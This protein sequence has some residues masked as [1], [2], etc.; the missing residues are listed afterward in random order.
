[1]PA[2][3]Y[4]VVIVGHGLAQS[5]AYLTAIANVFAARGWMV[6]AIDA[7]TFG[8]RAP[9]AKFQVDNVTDYQT[10]PGVAYKGPDGI[11][12]EVRGEHNGPLDFFGA[13]K[14][15]GAL[16]DQLR[17]QPFDISQVVKLLRQSPDLSPLDTGSGAP[18]I[19]S[20]K[21][22]YFGDSFGA[23][24]GV[25]AAAIEPGVK[26]WV[27]NVVGGALLLEIAGHGP[28]I[29]ALLAAAG[30][31]NFQFGAE[32]FDESH[33]LNNIAQLITDPGDPI[34][35]AALLVKSPGPLK[36]RKTG[37]RNLLFTEVIY[38][39]L[40]AN[41]GGEALARAA[42]LGLALPN[43]GSNAGIADITNL[44][45]NVGRVPFLDVAPDAKGAIHDTPIPGVTS[46]MVQLSP[47]QHG[48]NAVQNRGLR[49]FAIPYNRPGAQPFKH[50]DE[51]KKLNVR[52]TY[53]ELQALVVRY[54]DDAFRGGVPNVV[55]IP[56][57]LRDVDDDG[58]MDA[59]DADPTNPH[60][61]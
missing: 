49:S 19:D 57:P 59:T 14:N 52:C 46:V 44:E 10:R 15:L 28:A 21:I 8:A 3:G 58:A 27:L 53:R 32:R 39:E 5:R 29:S 50:L 6:A 36:S 20:S 34:D 23:I 11:A 17:Q 41:E 60:V 33:P 7:V 31:F 45:N 48:Y 2:S 56:R 30:T 42:G 43:V 18:K 37:P 22:A 16:R 25:T 24:T 40:V 26:A 38:D 55:G 51:D 9:E 54:I 4:P 12:D 61:K 47:G 35:Y 13:L 1:M